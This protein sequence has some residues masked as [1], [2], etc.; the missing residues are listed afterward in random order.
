MT[1]KTNEIWELTQK[2]EN[3][4]QLGD[5]QK[6]IE[7]FSNIIEKEPS[8]WVYAHLGEAYRLNGSPDEAIDNFRQATELKK[9]YAWAYAHWGETLRLRGKDYKPAAREL[10]TKALEINPNYIWA[11]A[12]RGTSY[13]LHNPSLSMTNMLGRSLFGV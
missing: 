9:D 6:A 3:F 8:A 11:I 10:F 4:F 5:Y 1:V 7:I 12:H 2:G 13:Y